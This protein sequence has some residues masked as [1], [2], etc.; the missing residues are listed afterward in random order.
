M[1]WGWQPVSQREVAWEL[2][3]E[4]LWLLYSHSCGNGGSGGIVGA[5]DVL[6]DVAT[7]VP[8]LTSVM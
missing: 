2:G 5:G 1:S 8:C 7:W 3:E 4:V 6:S